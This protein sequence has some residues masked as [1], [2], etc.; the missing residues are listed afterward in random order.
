MLRC[1]YYFE[2]I[3]MS[4]DIIYIN[5]ILTRLMRGDTTFDSNVNDFITFACEKAPKVPSFI[6]SFFSFFKHPFGFLGNNKL[7]TNEN[8]ELKD[9]GG[10][11]DKLKFHTTNDKFLRIGKF[12][13]GLDDDRSRRLDY[14]EMRDF[15][16]SDI[17][18]NVSQEV[19]EYRLYYNASH[20]PICFGKL[21][22][23]A[24][25]SFLGITFNKV[26]FQILKSTDSSS[27][28]QGQYLTFTINF[29]FR[30]SITGEQLIFYFLLGILF[31]FLISLAM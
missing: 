16:C 24:S 8:I 15:W 6:F 20:E 26:Y 31:T 13:I 28:R 25:F 14:I 11:S 29:R 19:N 22:K 17:T 12:K 10:D 21:I 4:L 9:Y 7:S 27:F 2:V 18:T 30:I 3:L 1:I 23:K 5:S